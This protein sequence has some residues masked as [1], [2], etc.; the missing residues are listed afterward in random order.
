[1]RSRECRDLDSLLVKLEK[2]SPNRRVDEMLDAAR[3]SVQALDAKLTAS[4]EEA[5][6]ERLRR[7][8]ELWDAEKAF[9]DGYA[10]GL[11]DGYGE[12]LDWMARHG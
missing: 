4:H 6:A 8:R 9:Q 3:M 11:A 5:R 1:M 10:Q 7:E 12:C 2:A